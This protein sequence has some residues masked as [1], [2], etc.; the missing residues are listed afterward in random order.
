MRTATA[1]LLAVLVLSG[2]HQAFGQKIDYRFNVP[3][4][5]DFFAP[6]TVGLQSGARDVAGPYDLDGDGVVEVLVA[7]YSGGGRV[8]VLESVGVDTWELVYSTPALDSTA[9]TN[10]IRAI[11]GGDMDG[12]GMGEIYFLAGRN[13][14]ENNPNIDKLPPGLYIFEAQGNDDFGSE[15]TTIW[16]FDGD[17]PDRWRTEQMI[18]MD[19]D[20]DGGDE[21]LISN[22][23]GDNRYDNWYVI[24]ATDIN[25]TF[26]TIVQEL[27]L[28]SRASEDFDPVDRGGGSPYSMVPGDLDGDGN[29]E[30]LLHSWN[31]FNLTNVRVTGPNQYVAPDENATN[32]FLHASA[33][34]DHVAFFGCTGVDING[35]GDTEV[36][37]PN[38]QTGAVTV[39]NYESGENALEITA[40]NV[41]VGIIP[42]F[43]TLGL[44]A[45]DLDGDGNIGLIGTARGYSAADFE[46]GNPAAWIHYVEYIGG[47]VE[48]PASYS[49]VV[50]IVSPSDNYDAFH[51]IVAADETITYSDAAVDA[52]NPLDVSLGNSNPEFASKFAFLGD[53]DGDG[54]NEVAFGIQGVPD[55]LYV[56]NAITE[57]SLTVASVSPNTH[58]IFMRVLAGSATG[59]SVEEDRIILPSDYKLHE[60][61]PN[62][63]NPT[64]T[65][66]F[67]LPI[68]KRVSVKVYDITGRLVRTLVNGQA[69]PAGTHE[70]TWDGTS[71]AGQTVA[72]GTYLYSL[73]YGSFRQT[74]KMVLIK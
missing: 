23:G 58:R 49:P 4:S 30:I 46:A 72:S 64:T 26:P 44:T 48:D 62:P 54:E 27:R 35:D 8:H 24:G 65:I 61:Y 39:I 14:D 40:D 29:I 67:T 41:S 16:E 13:Y 55:S 51:Q 2:G 45:G 70:V 63:F 31:A 68:D 7:D 12:D 22:N 17:L 50:E 15:P 56:L 73:E 42:G 18:A 53:V 57:D 37:C 28:S 32:V 74:R 38:L 10:N 1:L 59:V 60:N 36:Y 11:A 66:A 33:P 6:Y 25:D 21:L 19:I 52:R 34:D 71:D 9:T 20:G 47:D 69:Y 5:E 3:T 43:S